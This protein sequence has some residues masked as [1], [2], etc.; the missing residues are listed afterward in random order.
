[1]RHIK[2]FLLFIIVLG[3][4]TPF[5]SRAQ[6]LEPD[7]VEIVRAKILNIETEGSTTLPVLN[8]ATMDE[9]ITAQI[10]EGTQKGQTVSFS[11]NYPGIKTGEI[12]YI[13]HTIYAGSGEE[14][15]SVTDVDRLPVI[16]FFI[17]LFIM[18]AIIIFIQHRID[19][20]TT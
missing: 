20:K 9:N 1:M 16:Y 5:I 3:I 7:Q 14:T 4:F 11:D 6:E 12:I 2:Y 19:P 8:I 10:L 15:Y 18:L 17:G 13:N